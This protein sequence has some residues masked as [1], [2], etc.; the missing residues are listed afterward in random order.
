MLK[1]LDMALGCSEYLS[2]F[3][4]SVIDINCLH[5]PSLKKSLLLVSFSEWS[6]GDWF[7]YILILLS[8]SI[9]LK[10]LQLF[11]PPPPHSYT[12]SN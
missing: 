4:I 3:P 6:M 10:S 2:N 11:N 7:A 1:D 9:S 12:G 8:L 5:F